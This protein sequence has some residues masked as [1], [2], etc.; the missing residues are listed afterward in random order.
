MGFFSPDIMGVFIMC[1]QVKGIETLVLSV[2]EKT[3]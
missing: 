2:R 3:L 1:Y